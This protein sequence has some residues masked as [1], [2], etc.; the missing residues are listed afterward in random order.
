MKRRK[1]THQENKKLEQL[2][3]R[4]FEQAA[5]SGIP[6]MSDFDEQGVL[7]RI[8]RGIRKRKMRTILLQAAAAAVL[9]SVSVLAWQVTPT[10]KQPAQASML[11]FDA[12]TGQRTSIT[13]EDGTTVWLNAG[14][15]LRYPSAF[16]KDKRE[17][18]IEGEA[19][20]DVREDAQRPFLVHTG[21]VTTRVLGTTFNIVAYPEEKRIEI[22]VLSGKVSTSGKGD[23]TLLTP[24]QQAVYA[25]GGQLMAHHRIAD[26]AETI[27]WK[28]NKLIYKGKQL[29]QVIAALERWYGIQIKADNALLQCTVS[30]DFTGEPADKVLQ[31]LASLVNGAMTQENGIYSITGKGCNY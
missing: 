18:F 16:A 7:D 2:I 14:S 23:S 20:L 15:H 31:V 9:I 30:A 19:Y 17:V 12:G 24:D 28:S 21:D 25:A 10:R 5:D 13:L 11:Q 29:S 26:A 1:H 27:H 6:P 8:G 3:D 4:H 22:T